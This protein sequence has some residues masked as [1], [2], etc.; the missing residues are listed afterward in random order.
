MRR[1]LVD[2]ERAEVEGLAVL[3]RSGA[4]GEGGWKEPK[5]IRLYVISGMWPFKL[6]R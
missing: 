5:A 6:Q 1:L 2:L 4:A 3:I